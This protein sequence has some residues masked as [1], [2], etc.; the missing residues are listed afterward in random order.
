M[1]ASDIGIEKIKINAGPAKF[2]LENPNV[3]AS[4]KSTIEGIRLAAIIDGICRTEIW[5]ELT[6]KNYRLS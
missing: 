3:P 6:S 1:C 2:I 5:F 4:N